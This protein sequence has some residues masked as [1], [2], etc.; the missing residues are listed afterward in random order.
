MDR[1]SDR[2]PALG[3]LEQPGSLWLH[4]TPAT[5]FTGSQ[6]GERSSTPQSL[7]FCSGQ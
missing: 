6:L 4:P 5:V 3:P 1:A 7:G 2:S